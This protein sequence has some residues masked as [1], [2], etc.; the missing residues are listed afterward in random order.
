MCCLALIQHL[1]WKDL[2]PC[3]VSAKKPQQTTKTFSEA[4]VFGIVF[5]Y[6]QGMS[7]SLSDYPLPSSQLNMEKFLCINFVFCK[8]RHHFN[9]P[10]DDRRDD[11]FGQE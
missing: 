4:S 11:R 8:N 6:D 10:L 5:D 7:S 9:W 3:V 1:Q 2:A